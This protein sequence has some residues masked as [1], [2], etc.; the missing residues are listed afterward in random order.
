MVASGGARKFNLFSGRKAEFFRK[1]GSELLAAH[2]YPYADRD[3]FRAACDFVNVLF[4]VDEISDDQN[5]KDA[6]QTGTVFYKA[7]SD[8]NFDDGSILCT[9]TKQ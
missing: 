5:G 7:L 6:L 2:A 4:V 3:R 9:M 1:R 8:P